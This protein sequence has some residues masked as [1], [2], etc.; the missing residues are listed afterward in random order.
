MGILRSV[1]PGYFRAMG[2]PLVAGR[3][4]ADSDNKPAA[5]VINTLTRAPARASGT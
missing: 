2:I 3:V 1:T 4:F 5:P